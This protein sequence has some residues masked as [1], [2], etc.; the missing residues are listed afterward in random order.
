MPNGERV[1]SCLMKD[2][3]FDGVKDVLVYLG[4]FGNSGIE[5]FEAFVWSAETKQYVYAAEFKNIPN[6]YISE[7]DKCILSAARCSAAED[8]YAQYVYEKGLFM[9][10]AELRQYWKGNIYPE[11]DKAI[12]EE[13][14]IKTN[15]WKKNLKLNQISKFWRPVL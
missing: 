6:P 12:Y 5:Y 2:I 13:H 10:I 7:K 14:F 3:N 4:N 11:K 9:K 8:N 1:D 15:V